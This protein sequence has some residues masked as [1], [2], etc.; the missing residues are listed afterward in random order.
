M[1]DTEQEDFAN[2]NEEL[3]PKRQVNCMDGLHIT[4]SAVGAIMCA[5]GN[6]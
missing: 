4:I 3:I 1:G 5:S 6:V 2:K